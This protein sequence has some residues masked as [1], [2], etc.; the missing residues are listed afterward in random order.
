MAVT[1]KFSEVSWRLTGQISD[2]TLIFLIESR[3]ILERPQHQQNFALFELVLSTIHF[4]IVAFVSTDIR[5]HLREIRL[6]PKW[7]FIRASDMP[8]SWHFGG[9]LAI[10]F[11]VERMS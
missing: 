8:A 3:S 7:T 9:I 4:A 1:L 10:S 5:Q 2:S 11:I 6:I